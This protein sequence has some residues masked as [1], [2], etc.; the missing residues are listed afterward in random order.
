MIE[1]SLYK[2]RCS[3]VLICNEAKVGR[4]KKIS[5]VN[6]IR[7]PRRQDMYIRQDVTGGRDKKDKLKEDRKNLGKS[8]TSAQLG[9]KGVDFSVWII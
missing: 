7:S 3:S 6:C 1:T 5:R 4:L 9:R 8:E 2:C